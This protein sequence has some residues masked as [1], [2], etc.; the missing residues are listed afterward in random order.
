MIISGGSS[1]EVE[2]NILILSP[3]ELQKLY[4]IM[5]PYGLGFL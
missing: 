5:S 4:A 3:L 2:V 1:L